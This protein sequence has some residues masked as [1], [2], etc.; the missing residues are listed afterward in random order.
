VG[1]QRV[2]RRPAGNWRRTGWDLGLAC[3]DSS[4]PQARCARQARDAQ[5]RSTSRGNFAPS[6]RTGDG[7]RSGQQRSERAEHAAQTHDAERPSA[8]VA[9]LTPLTRPASY[10]QPTSGNQ[11]PATNNQQAA[12]GKRQ[13]ATNNQQPNNQQSAI[14]N[15]AIRQSGNPAIGN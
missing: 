15:R 8:T 11:Q 2:Q 1:E 14:S 13:S 6:G 10:Q 12:S 3:G 7:H 9:R 5:D 4:L